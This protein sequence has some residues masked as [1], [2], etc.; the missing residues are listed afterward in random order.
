MTKRLRLALV[1]PLG[2]ILSSCLSS[3]GPTT[4]PPD[5]E[6]PRDHDPDKGAA[7]V[8]VQNHS[9]QDGTIA[10]VTV[11]DSVSHSLKREH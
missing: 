10:P 2:V 3:T 11:A 8:Q 5:D 9:G 6:N 1:L 4:M 7:V